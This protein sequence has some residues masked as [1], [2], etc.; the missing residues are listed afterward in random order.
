[1]VEG[2]EAL[3]RAQDGMADIRVVSCGSKRAV[4]NPCP[5]EVA[6]G[7][8]IGDLT[9]IASGLEEGQ[10]VVASGQFLLDSE[11]SLRGLGVDAEEMEHQP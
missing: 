9:I 4:P 1:M 7:A 3:R 11:A 2:R 8:E 5:V 6:L 10:K